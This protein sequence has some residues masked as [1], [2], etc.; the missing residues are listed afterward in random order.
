MSSWKRPKKSAK[1]SSPSRPLRLPGLTETLGP[2]DVL[3]VVVPFGGLN[4]PS[5]GVHL[6]QACGRSAGFR[7]GVLISAR[8]GA[9]PQL[10][11]GP[12]LVFGLSIRDGQA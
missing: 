3:L 9:Q 10:C 8:A 4:H 5:F 7:V 11:H 2:A 1:E 6:L 12:P